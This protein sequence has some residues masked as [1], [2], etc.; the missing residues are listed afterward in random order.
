[1][2]SATLT[3][4]VRRALCLIAV[5]TLTVP[6]AAT[7][8]DLRSPDARDAAQGRYLSA[9][10]AGLQDLR[11]PDARDAAQGRYLSAT[12]VGAQDLPAPARSDTA[13]AARGLDWPS[14]AIGAVMFGGLV[15]VAYAASGLLRRARTPV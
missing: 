10:P 5:C 12:P 11:S 3:H 15:L 7:A 6:A 1:M 2:T 14:A 4:S 13:P 9:T 8:Q